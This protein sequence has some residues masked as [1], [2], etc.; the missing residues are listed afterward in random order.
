MHPVKYVVPV[1]LLVSAIAMGVGLACSSGP[2]G[3]PA[4]D[5]EA[6]V[7]LYHA[8][9]GADWSNNTNWLS[10]ASIDEWHGVRVDDNGRVAGLGLTIN[11]LVGGISAELGKLSNLKWLTLGGNQLSGEIPPEL[12]NLSNLEWLFLDNNRLSGKIPAELGNL[13]D[14]GHLS[15]GNNRLSGCIPRRLRT[16]LEDYPSGLDLPFCTPSPA[17]LRSPDRP[18]LVA[19]YNAMGGPRWSENT[20]WL[21]AA[22]IDEWYGVRVD[23]SG[24]VAELALRSNRL[25][26]GIPAELSDL[27]NLERLWLGDNQLSGEIPAELGGISNLESLFLDGNQLS[28]EIPA[29]LGGLSNLER[30]R[31]DNNQLSGEI[32]AQL[33]SLSNL[34]SLFLGGNQLSGEIP[35]ELGG[36]SNL[37]R[38]RLDN[39]QLSGEIPA[40]L[41]G[42]A[43]LQ[44][45]TAVALR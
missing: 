9:N 14:L 26:G 15:L 25:V 23:D 31:L 36:L 33:G 18:L 19:L 17:L 29:E 13:S 7:A 45:G 10:P 12:G 30:L 5:R 27:S 28:G 44:P 43:A 4:S 41:D 16:A 1:L 2:T 35:A 3:S 24:R 22:P 39:N 34:E 32:P 42:T 21:S 40:E 6:L 20:N 8:T 11:R 37:E 38:L